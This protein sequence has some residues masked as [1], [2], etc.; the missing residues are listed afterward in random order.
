MFSLNQS[1]NPNWAQ[2]KSFPTLERTS[3]VIC[4]RGK[5]IFSGNSKGKILIVNSASL[6]VK[7]S[8][9]VTQTAAA[10]N[11]VKVSHT[12]LCFHFSQ[13]I[14]EVGGAKKIYPYSL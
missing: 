11:A 14:K 6:E 4:R 9:K 2:K 7:S 12:T 8:F 3:Y 5:F 1:I 13:G 10:N